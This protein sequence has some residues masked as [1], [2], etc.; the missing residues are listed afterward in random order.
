MQ[1]FIRYPPEVNEKPLEKCRS[2]KNKLNCKY[3]EF[4]NNSTVSYGE[5]DPQIAEFW[6]GIDKKIIQR[7]TKIEARQIVKRDGES[8][9]HA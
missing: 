1:I 9:L 5:L 7:S 4:K 2:S 3:I 8:E 6:N